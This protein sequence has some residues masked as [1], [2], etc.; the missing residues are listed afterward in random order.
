MISQTVSRQLRALNGTFDSFID[1]MRCHRTTNSMAK[2]T[3]KPTNPAK[4]PLFRMDRHQIDRLAK[5]GCHQL[6]TFPD[7]INQTKLDRLL[8]CPEGTAEQIIMVAGQ[9]ATTPVDNI[10]DELLVN[11]LLQRLQPVDV[12][13]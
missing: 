4:K 5:P 10:L 9:L 8:T 11:V 3:R 6:S 1:H 2:S 12:T 13:F 7:T